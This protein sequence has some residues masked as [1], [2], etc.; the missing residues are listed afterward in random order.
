MTDAV[1]DR[2][3]GH[4]QRCRRLS[5]ASVADHGEEDFEIAQ[6]ERHKQSL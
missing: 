1:A 5:E 6:V 3:L 2:R 4:D